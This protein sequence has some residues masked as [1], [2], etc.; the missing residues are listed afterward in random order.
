MDKTDATYERV[1]ANGDK[2][3]GEATIDGGA[4]GNTERRHEETIYEQPSSK[5][6]EHF[7]P[8]RALSKVKYQK[9]ENKFFELFENFKKLHAN[10]HCIDTIVEMLSY[11]KSLKKISSKL[12]D[13]GRFT[14]PYMIDITYFQKVLCKLAANINLMPF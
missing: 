6:F 7:I 2:N 8:C 3:V 13:L 5:P 4:G 12:K 11:A 14:I 9:K 10:D 1:K